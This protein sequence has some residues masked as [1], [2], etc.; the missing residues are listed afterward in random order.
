MVNEVAKNDHPVPSEREMAELFEVEELESRL[1]MCLWG[2][3]CD[4]ACN[5]NGCCNGC[6]INTVC[7]PGNISCFEP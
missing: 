1:E 3:G 6:N 7:N 4:N 5:P 2:I